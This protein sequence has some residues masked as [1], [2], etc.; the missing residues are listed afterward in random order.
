MA[1]DAGVQL[2]AE[3]VGAVGGEGAAVGGFVDR[4]GLAVAID[5]GGGGVDDRGSGA[6]ERVENRDR[7]G[8][9]GFMGAGPIV[10]TALH[11][12]DGGEVEAA[13]H[14]LCRFRGGF[15]IGDVAFQEID[16]RGK[17]AQMAR[18]QIVQHPHP[19]AAR[20]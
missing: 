2:A 16:A 15:R 10:D 18:G 17:V 13:V 8:Q 20:D 1:G 9:V 19:V 6:P 5:G 4:D 7:A 14:V 3:L 11:R 12:G